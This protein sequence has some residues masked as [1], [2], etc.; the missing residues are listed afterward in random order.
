MPDTRRKW[1]VAALL[2]LLLPGLGQ[3]YNGQAKKGIWFYILLLVPGLAMTLGTV[4][5]IPFVPLVVTSFAISLLGLFL[6]LVEAVLS[7]R[8]QSAN[9][10]YKAYNKWQI[11]LVAILASTFLVTPGPFKA[12]VLGKVYM[13]IN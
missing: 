3:V 5:G 13:S 8:K 4:V 6:I 9:Y 2:G 11:Y 10:Q 1:W 12:M 7:A